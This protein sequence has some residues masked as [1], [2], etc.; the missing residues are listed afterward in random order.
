MQGKKTAIL[1][2]QRMFRK[3]GPVVGVFL[4]PEQQSAPSGV[5]NWWTPLEL[6]G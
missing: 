3:G 2:I 6:H 1:N 5:S 4:I